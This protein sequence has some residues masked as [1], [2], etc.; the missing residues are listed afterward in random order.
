LQPYLHELEEERITLSDYHSQKTRILSPLR[1]MPAEILREIFS[2]TLPP[3]DNFFSSADCP[4][5]LTHV[6][7]TW[8]AVALS[9]PSLWSV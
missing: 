2:W 8:R 6:C 4:W 7:A 5:I 3:V 9:Q 1:R